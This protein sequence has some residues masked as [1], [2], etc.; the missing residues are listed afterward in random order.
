[1]FTESAR[2]LPLAI[3]LFPLVAAAAACD[4]AASRTPE[5]SL[6]VDT[7]G[8]TIVVRTEGGS[9]WGGEPR[10]VER[11]RIGT[12]DGS[13][14]Y[15]FGRI[16]ALAMTAD[17]TI[18]M[19]DSQIPVV[20]VFSR[21]GRHLRSFGRR[22][23]GPG[24][25]RQPTGLA[26]LPDGRVLIS[27]PAN[28]RVS[29]YSADGEPLDS[30]RMAGGFFTDEQVRVTRDGRV[31]VMAL[32]SEPMSPEMRSG[33]VAVGPAGTHIDTLHAPDW[34]YQTAVL[35]AQFQQGESRSISRSGVPFTPQP[36][37]TLHPDGYIV[38]GLSTR[39]AIEAFHRDGRV[40]RMER[41]V[42]PVA[43]LPG[44]RAHREHAVTTSMR[45]TDPAWRWSG[46]AIPS[47]KP[48]FSGLR[49]DDD[50]RIWVRVA[51]V[52]E[53]VPAAERPEPSPGAAP[54]PE[55]WREPLVFDVFA[56]DGRFLGTVRP[57]PRFTLSG[58]RG[59]EV[60]GVIRDEFDVQYIAVLQIDR[61]GR[62]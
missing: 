48:P 25:L 37:W 27:D 32:L 43:V 6:R 58:A 50:G 17:G 57:P 12:L 59:D 2:R 29:V 16:D 62:T 36:T 7:V 45:R 30:W 13:E 31:Y 44:E 56:A 39:Y 21:D 14:E 60:W 20:R 23:E 4:R 35:T 1:M 9:V 11:L 28:A 22:G 34:G 18:Y 61:S 10:L 53:V 19:L 49:V 54:G 24:E 26:L 47:T 51:A 46:P 52:A 3:A 5:L 40:V 38:G 33:L 41:A 8:D 55:P 15:T 42:E